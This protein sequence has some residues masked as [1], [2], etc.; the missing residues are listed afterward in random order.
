MK[1]VSLLFGLLFLLFSYFQ[2]NDPDPEIWISIYSAAALACYMAHKRLWP[3]WIFYGLAVAFLIGT[4]L[5]WPPEFEGIFF[6]DLGMR[7]LNIELARE[8]LGLGICAVAMGLLGWLSSRP[9]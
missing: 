7:S 3:Y 9:E 5:V 6:G 1:F 2:F 8:S 4:F